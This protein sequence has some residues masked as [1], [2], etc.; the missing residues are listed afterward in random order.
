MHES[1]SLV[2]F[3][4]ATSILTILENLIYIAIL[5]GVLVWLLRFME[6]NK[7]FENHR[8]GRHRRR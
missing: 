2:S 1:Y 6:R 5:I 3:M 8:K 7:M 4:V